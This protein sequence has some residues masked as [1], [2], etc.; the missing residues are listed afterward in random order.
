M[1]VLVTGATGFL[2]GHCIAELLGAGCAVR[3]TVRNLR[4]ADVAHLRALPGD[5]EFV[6]ADLSSDAGWAEAVAG[7]DYVWHVASP[8]PSSVPRD[9][10]E[11][12]RPAVD[13]TLRV[14]RAAESSGTVRRVVM[15]SSGLTVQGA[16]VSTEADWADA[17]TAAPYPKSKILAE[18]AAWEFARNSRV[19]LVVL[20]PGAI[21]GP[22]QRAAGTNSVEMIGRMMRGALPLVPKIGWTVVDVRDLARLH[23]LAMETPAAAG[24]RYIAGD[25]FIWAR[26]MAGVL[27]DRYRPRGYR[28]RTGAMPYA[29]MWL[30]A[31]V[32]PS[33]RLGLSFWGRRHPV[34]AAK[35]EKELGWVSR[36]PAESVL[37]TAESLIETGLVPRR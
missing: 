7:C 3:G 37:D 20:N 28:I 2:A 18:R 31:R 21:F 6:E 27:A 30:I 12:I 15:T 17:D 8:F 9:E 14:L 26:E 13:G 29:M 1:R 25:Q 24:R 34:S 16:D 5:L 35:A 23:R 10:N 4:T 32:D 33:V 19:E 36:P 22:L 11:V